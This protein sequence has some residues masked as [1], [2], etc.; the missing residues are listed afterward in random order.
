MFNGGRTN[1]EL[2]LNLNRLHLI[3]LRDVG[4]KESNN[5]CPITLAEA[6]ETAVGYHSSVQKDIA[7]I[8]QR[9]IVL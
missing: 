7:V 5:D 6:D 3:C 8:C 9:T 4:G 2:K 1:K